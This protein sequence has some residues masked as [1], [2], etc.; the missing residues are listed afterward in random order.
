MEKSYLWTKRQ[1]RLRYMGSTPRGNYNWLFL[2]DGPWLGS[3]SLSGLSQLLKEITIPSASYSFTKKWLNKSI[4]LFK[5]LSF[6][7]KTYE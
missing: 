1:A 7:Y 3:E 6:N 2:P 5:T 4:A